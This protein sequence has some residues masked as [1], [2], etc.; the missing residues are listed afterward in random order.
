MNDNSNPY[1]VAD[2]RSD[3]EKY[4]EGWGYVLGTPEAEEA[5][6]LKQA[7]TV[8]LAPM[9][10]PDLP[11]YLSPV[12]EKWVEGRAARREDLKRTGCRPYEGRDQEQKEIE[13]K[14]KHEEA[15]ADVARFDAVAKTFY[16]LPEQK[17]RALL[18][19]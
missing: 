4:L 15:K 12:S 17:R 8:R 13:R 10:A 2:S 19:G 18:R 6:N 9:I 11:G 5:W 1:Y 3:K 16:A 7:Q 14:S